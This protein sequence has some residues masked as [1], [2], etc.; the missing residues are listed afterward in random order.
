MGFDFFA[1]VAHW[2]ALVGEKDFRFAKRT[3]GAKGYFYKMTP[4]GENRA[5][6]L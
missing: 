2:R 4:S 5:A 3:R 6:F 1:S